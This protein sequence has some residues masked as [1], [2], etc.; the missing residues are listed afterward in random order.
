MFKDLKVVELASVLA[1]P[2]VGMFFAELG[3]QVIKI[4][5]K[6]TGGDVTRSWK[7]PGEDSKSVA[8]A[9]FSSVNWGKQ[10]VFLDLSDFEDRK[11]V[12][13]VMEQAD[14]VI[15]NFKVGDANKLGMD[16]NTLSIYNSK[17]IYLALK[18]FN[19]NIRRT[20]YD[21]VV[22]AETGYMYMNGTADGP[23]TKMPLAFM[24][25]LA[26]HQMKEAILVALL[27]RERT[28]EGGFMEV[29]LEESAIA[30]LANQASNWLMAK[31]IPQRMG[32]LHPNIAPYGETFTTADNKEIVLAVGSD[33]Q[34][35]RLC[36]VLQ[37]PALANDERFATNQARVIHRAEMAQALAPLIATQQRDALLTTLIQQ[38]VPAGAIRNM[39][40]VFATQ[41][42]QNMV[43]EEIL[44]DGTVT[45]RVK[46]IAFKADFLNND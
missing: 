36:T 32:S 3:A 16:Y 9:Y 18:G 30:S 44:E 14:V 29:S 28:G 33:A 27:H 8:S 7:L 13:E 26:A 31:H 41:T 24:D 34:F 43:L 22:Q 35:Q 20:A 23:P 37:H 2:A 21:V 25:L 4:E 19:E 12:Y 42:A 40:E 5:N 11:F 1:G 45:K 6:K 46:T 15:A 39:E 10:H 38:N 17:L